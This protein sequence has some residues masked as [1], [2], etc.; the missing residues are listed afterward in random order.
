LS[1]NHLQRLSTIKLDTLTRP[2]PP[3][4]FSVG[5]TTYNRSELL[6]L[7]LNSLIKQTFLDFEI[8]IGNDYTHDVLSA[9]LLGIEDSRI[10]F[11][12]N[13]Q[14]LGEIGNMN[15]L[16][17]MA[18]GR[19]FTWLA[20]DDLCAPD[21]LEVVHSVLV[22]FGSLPCVFTS[23][24]IINGIA[25]PIL[26]KISLGRPKFFSGRHFLRMYLAGKVKAMSC[27]GVFDTNYL[28]QI[29]GVESLCDAPIGLYGE[30]MLMV[31]CG[32]LEKVAFVDAPLVLYRAH[33]GSWSADGKYSVDQYKQAGMNLVH[34]SVQVLSKPELQKDF[35]HNLTSLL[36]LSLI[37]FSYKLSARDHYLDRKE[38]N[39]YLV[40]L[41]E[42]FS[43]LKGTELYW[44]ALA[45]LRKIRVWLFWPIAKLKFKLAAPTGL[46]I[47][48]RIARSFLRNRN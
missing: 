30:Y 47:I 5:V 20:D 25:F 28:R 40:L 9:E 32:L 31:R 36:K 11:V 2:E 39:A 8:I 45:S 19:Y 1:T 41:K 24:K 37:N 3:P 10:S 18:R 43:F 12:N 22:E 23:Y 13:P 6:K 4:F 38:V 34:E 14:N 44:Q 27:N 46:I 26:S 7:T 42:R 29:G 48:I 35:C 17:G 33:E 15:S 16:L 21:F